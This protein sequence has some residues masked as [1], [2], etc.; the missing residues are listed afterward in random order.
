MYTFDD[1]RKVVCDTA[2]VR[3]F[4]QIT[5]RHPTRH[6]S[7]RLFAILQKYD[8]SSKSQHCCKSAI[9]R[10]SCL[11][12]C[13]STIFQA[14]HNA[15]RSH[16]NCRTVV[17]DTAK[18]RFF[19]QITTAWLRTP[20]G[21]RCL[22][23][24]KSTIF[25]ANHNIGAGAAVIGGVVCDTAKVRFFKQITTVTNPAQ[26]AVLLFAILQKYDF[27]SKS[28]QKE[29]NLIELAVVCDTAKV[30]FFKQITT[31]PPCSVSFARLFAILQKYD[32]SSKSQLQCCSSPLVK[33][34]LRYCKSTIFQANHNH[35]M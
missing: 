11:R 16:S 9:Y 19:K 8:F 35:L 29:Y 3:F 4:K 31:R 26:L 7:R 24:C 32:F 18:V 12:Y 1:G 2:K 25:Q 10:D 28:Q 34:C 30:R 15:S 23:Y 5:T 6:H 27:S 14:N 20:I 22:R 21:R 13:K 17:C 33:C